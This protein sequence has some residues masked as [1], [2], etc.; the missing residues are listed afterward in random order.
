LSIIPILVRA[1]NTESFP[2]DLHRNDG[3]TEN[4]GNT[5][6]KNKS[7]VDPHTV[8]PGR[9]NKHQY[10][11]HDVPEKSNSYE[12]IGQDLSVGVLQKRECDVADASYGKSDETEADA[13]NDP[14]HALIRALANIFLLYVARQGMMYLCGC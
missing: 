12:S 10:G 2:P 5:S 3:E 6:E 4:Y 8:E 14:R 1:L 13:G 7:I 11:G 9:N